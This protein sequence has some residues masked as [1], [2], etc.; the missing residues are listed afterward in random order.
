MLQSLIL[1]LSVFPI[2]VVTPLLEPRY[3]LIPYILLRVQVVNVPTW[4][5][6]VEGIWYTVIN[7][8]TMGVFLY[9]ER[10]GVG[11]FMW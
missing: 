5:V 10:S 11:R 4:A 9:R 3:F 8:V 1:P 2:L 6:I 7:G